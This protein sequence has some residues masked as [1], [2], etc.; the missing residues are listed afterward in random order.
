MASE[1]AAATTRR[2]VSGNVARRATR[3]SLRNGGIRSVPWW[4][5]PIVAC[6]QELGISTGTLAFAVAASSNAHMP[7]QPI[8]ATG[9]G[10]RPGR[11]VVLVVDDEPG[12]LEVLSLGLATD[13]LEVRTAR[14]VAG[15]LL[16]I[17]S[18]A[19]DLVILDVGLPGGNGFALLARIREESD[20]P[21]I[22]LTARGD[23]SDRVRGLE[24][25]ADD[26]VAKPFHLEELSARIRAH[27]RRRALDRADRQPAAQLRCGDIE[28]DVTAHEATRG[29]RRLDLTAR[30]FS[31]LELLLR[32]P[33]EVLP[34]TTILER[35]WGYAYDPNLVEVYVGYLRR[36]L[37][38]PPAIETVRGA[39][40]RIG[41]DHQDVAG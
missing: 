39:G 28:L 12:I 40:Y 7:T 34:K 10:S 6:D 15:G 1:R 17:Q 33:G 21:V 14:D 16:A 2:R 37:G 11:A 25:G 18:A 29:G 27:L 32:H 8:T 9:H 23:L 35:L 4:V 20:V 19:P 38:E 30:E 41:P 31:L 24:L 5:G 36:K 3:A 13:D 22:M 26:Y